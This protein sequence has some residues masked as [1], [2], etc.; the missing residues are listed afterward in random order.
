M[1]KLVRDNKVKPSDLKSYLEDA[2]TVM[3]E[4]PIIGAQV[5]R[6]DDGGH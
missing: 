5:Y 6:S 3:F 1:K 2:N 4:T